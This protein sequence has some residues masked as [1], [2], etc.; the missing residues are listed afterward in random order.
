MGNLETCIS[1][2]QD[3]EVPP[4]GFVE[5]RT[6]IVFNIKMDF[7]RK[8]QI[9]TD[10]SSTEV[11]PNYTY[12][13]VVSRD[14]ICIAFLYAALNDLDIMAGDVAATYLNAPVGEKVLF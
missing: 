10:G 4:P 7:T 13:S 2:V 12:A 8:A 14:S 9:I 11:D 3:G 5:I 6:H 1:I